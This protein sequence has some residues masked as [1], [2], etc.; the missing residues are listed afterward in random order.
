M[1]RMYDV[2]N[3]NT[4]KRLTLFLI[5]LIISVFISGYFGEKKVKEL[6]AICDI[7]IQGKLCWKWHVETKEGVYKILEDAK[8]TN[9]SMEK[10]LN[11]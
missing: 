1:S 4:S 11:P 9:F 7:G 5:F 8:G 6:G 2:P 3:H 10:I